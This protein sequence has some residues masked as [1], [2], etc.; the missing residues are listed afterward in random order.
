MKTVKGVYENGEVKLLEQYNLPEKGKVLVTFPDEIN[1]EEIIRHLS[2]QQ[3]SE[4]D[5]SYLKDQREDL[6][7]EYLKDI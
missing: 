1:D 3:I 6:Y 2:L 7:Q 5:K 4:A